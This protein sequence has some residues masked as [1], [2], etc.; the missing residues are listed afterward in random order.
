MGSRGPIP[1]RDAERRRCNKP[2]RPT[3]T[4]V[5]TVR[6]KAP[7]PD[8]DW[9]PIARRLYV[10]LKKSAQSQFFQASDWATAYLLAESISRD[11][12]P[13]V[14][15]IDPRGGTAVIETIPLK[16]ASLAAYLKA[17]AALGMTEGDRR[18]MRIEIEPPAAK[19]PAGVTEMNE[20][21]RARQG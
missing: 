2:D 11:L 5:S 17:F 21:R 12:S 9:H 20:Y 10:S 13:Q 1:K 8:K 18:R 19:T 14:V 7:A 4:L 15:G 6:A 16:G 3:D